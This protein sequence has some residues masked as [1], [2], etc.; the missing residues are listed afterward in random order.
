MIENEE[1]NNE[2]IGFLVGFI[3]QTDPAIGYIHF[4]G[5]N[6]LYRRRSIARNMYLHFEE[7]ITSKGCTEIHCLTD[8]NNRKS[9]SFHKSLGYSEEPSEDEPHLV[10]FCKY[11]NI[12]TI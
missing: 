12:Q 4:M 10:L 7:L 11:L 1:N 3:S 9:R 2:I 5:V 6:P 8:I